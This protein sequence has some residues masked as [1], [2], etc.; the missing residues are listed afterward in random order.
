MRLDMCENSFLVDMGFEMLDR[1]A[2][3]RGGDGIVPTTLGYTSSAPASPDC[4]IAREIRAKAVLGTIVAF[5]DDDRQAGQRVDGVP[6][7]APSATWS[8]C[9]REPADKAII[10]MPA[11]RGT[12]ARAHLRSTPGFARIRILPDVAQMVEG[13]AHLVSPRDRPTGHMG[14]QPVSIGLRRASVVGRKRV[15]VTGPAVHRL[16]LARQLLSAE[17]SA[18]TCSATARTRS[19]R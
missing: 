12:V 2:K 13:D 10:A 3:G 7:P 14:A 18:C 16:R 11:H 9:L 8:G 1:A 15:I 6:V 4:A 17:S 5:L 19:T